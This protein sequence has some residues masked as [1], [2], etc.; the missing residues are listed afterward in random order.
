MISGWTGTGCCGEWQYLVAVEDD[1]EGLDGGALGGDGGAAAGFGGV[2]RQV[3]G[4]CSG[5]LGTGFG[6]YGYGGGV[7]G[8]GVQGEEEKQRQQRGGG[9]ELHCWWRC[10]CCGVSGLVDCGWSRGMIALGERAWWV[11][12]AASEP[13]GY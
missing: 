6:W 13:G 11:R 7:V 8:L 4:E 3:V 2:G 12:V 1:G 10:G 5:G 9:G